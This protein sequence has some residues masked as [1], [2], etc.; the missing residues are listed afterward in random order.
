M[1]DTLQSSAIGKALSG[2]FDDISL[3]LRQ[4]VQLAKAEIAVAAAAQAKTAAYFV[5]SAV[6][7]FV[8]LLLLCQSAVLLLIHGGLEAHWACLSV[9]A[10]VALFA[11][12]AFFIGRSSLARHSAPHRTLVQV[13]R[14]IAAVKEGLS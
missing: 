9:T 4:E 12:A 6:L 14:D 11:I 1:L 13:R 8:T 10:A 3:L 7:G 2:L 5:A